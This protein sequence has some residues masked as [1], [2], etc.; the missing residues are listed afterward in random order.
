M[1]VVQEHQSNAYSTNC[2]RQQGEKRLNQTLCSTCSQIR[3]LRRQICNSHIEIDTASKS[4]AHAF[5]L[6]RDINAMSDQ[7]PN[8]SRA[9]AEIVGKG[10]PVPLHICLLDQDD[11]VRNLLWN[12]VSNSASNNSPHEAGIAIVG[13]KANDDTINKVMEEVTDENW[14]NDTHF[15]R[16]GF[17]LQAHVHCRTSLSFGRMFGSGECTTV[18]TI[19]S[20]CGWLHTITN[21]LSR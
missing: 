1:L 2:K 10:R 12:L 8:E 20:D 4:Q 17:W 9:A 7:C 15:D 16:F 13:C 3:Q 19:A 5:H 14:P 18:S 6:H 21:P 11:K